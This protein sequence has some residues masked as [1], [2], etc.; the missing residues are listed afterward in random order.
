M[1]LS[2]AMAPEIG[3]ASRARRA[4]PAADAPYRIL[5][6]DPAA[7]SPRRRCRLTHTFH[8]H[9]LMQIDALEG[10]AER[11]Y[12]QGQC[13]F[14][15]PGSTLSSEF[16]HKPKS[17]DGRSL[18][19]VFRRIDEP[20]SWIALYDI[21]VDPLYRAFL[22]EV[23]D[24]VRPL[25]EP[26]ERAFDLRGFVFISAPPS[27]TPFHIDREN[28]FWLQIR[29]RKTIDVWDR[30]DRA[31][32][33]ARDVEDFIVHRTLDRVKLDDRLRDRSLQA[34]CGPGDGV[35]FPST[36]PHMTQSCRD[37][38][39]PGDG[40][41]ISIGVDFYTD[42][43]RRNARVHAFNRLLRKAGLAPRLPGRSDA[44]DRLKAPFGAAAV[45]LARRL[46]GYTPPPGL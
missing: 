21:Q 45:A 10:L 31:V 26:H 33:A 5:V 37:W 4:A 8:L 39:T 9:P 14:L 15:R 11:L 1:S 17:A 18:A 44:L 46:R 30:D 29:G 36:S 27:V 42:V 3:A 7:Y 13:R 32:V 40:V 22:A 38:T 28:N 12:P 24:T 25:V 20:G 41:A 2:P 19:D 43:T 16:S 34:D 35:Y 23:Y 6:E